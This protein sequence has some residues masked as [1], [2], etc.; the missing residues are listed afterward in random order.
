MKIKKRK[1]NYLKKGIYKQTK[2]EIERK[3][4]AYLATKFELSIGDI[5]RLKYLAKRI[6]LK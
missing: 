3:N 6:I 5:R 2:F 4:E 1:R